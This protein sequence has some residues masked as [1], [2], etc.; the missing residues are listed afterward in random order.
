MKLFIVILFTKAFL[1][2]ADINIQIYPDSIYVGMLST[3]NISV[4]NLKEGEYPVFYEILDNPT[5][6]SII[7]RKLDKLSAEFILQFWKAKNISIPPVIIE[8]RKSKNVLYKLVSDSISINIFSNIDHNNSVIKPIKPM[9]DFRISTHSKVLLCSIFAFGIISSLYLWKYK[10][11]NNTVK[12]YKGNH[13]TSIFNTTIHKL[14][15]LEC[16]KN[17]NYQS[18][19]LYYLSLSS[20]CRLFI[21]E[22]FFI[23]ATEMTTKELEQYFQSISV[24][25]ELINS[26]VK[27]NNKADQAKY[28]GLIIDSDQYNLDKANFINII[29]SFQY[30]NE[31]TIN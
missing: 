17:I 8:I 4:I 16:P 10:K 3:I 28:S 19:E 22:T 31:R 2:S 15:V 1:F 7:D 21:K 25:Q 18:T 29:K 24:N 13:K 20:I 14:K 11:N 12:F 5:S 26:W 23:R 6:Y 9:N 27:V 30:F